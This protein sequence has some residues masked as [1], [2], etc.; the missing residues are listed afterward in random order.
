MIVSP[1]STH[2]STF[3]RIGVRSRPVLRRNCSVVVGV[4]RAA[5]RVALVL[6]AL[7]AVRFRMP[8]TLQLPEVLLA[9]ALASTSLH[10]TAPSVL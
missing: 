2:A 5:M 8:T 7:L 4:D 10:C 1:Q 9:M 3:L 6:A